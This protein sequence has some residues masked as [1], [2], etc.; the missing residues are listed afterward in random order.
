[1]GSNVFSCYRSSPRA[2]HASPPARRCPPLV[3]ISEWERCSCA[4]G[5][6]TGSTRWASIWRCRGFFRRISND[7]SSSCACSPGSRGRDHRSACALA[8]PDIRK[9]FALACLTTLVPHGV[10]LFASTNPSGL[11]I[12]SIAAFWCAALTLLLDGDPRPRDGGEL[13]DALGAIGLLSRSDAGIYL[14]IAGLAAWVAAAGHRRAARARSIVVLGVGV[15]GAAAT[16]VTRQ[17]QQ[18][19]GEL[20]VERSSFV[21]EL[22]ESALEVPQSVLGCSA[23]SSSSGST[24]VPALTSSPH[25]RRLWRHDRRRTGCDVPREVARS[26]GSRR[27]CRRPSGS[28]PHVG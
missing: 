21:A 2:L 6:T 24:A 20:G 27:R 5:L 18:L 11:A 8:R 13:S 22:F 26:R 16:L 1:M 4:G 23:S 14:V 10:F 7:R 19:T 15:V 17:S 28:C 3:G 12:A 9:A 25:T